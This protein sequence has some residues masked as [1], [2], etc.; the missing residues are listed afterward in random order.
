MVGVEEAEVVEGTLEVE[1]MG[2]DAAVL[3][4]T[5]EGTMET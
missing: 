4:S 3:G 5:S 1:G 2:V